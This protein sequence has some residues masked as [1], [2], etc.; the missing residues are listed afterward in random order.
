M[1]RLHVA[2]MQHETC[3]LQHFGHSGID[4]GTHYSTF[5][6]LEVR[7]GHDNWWILNHK[8]NQLGKIDV[9]LFWNAATDETFIVEQGDIALDQPT[10]LYQ[11][12][13]GRYLALQGESIALPQEFDMLYA[14]K[15][16]ILLQWETT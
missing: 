6:N 13:L 16:K 12:A 9:A 1:H 15:S 14:A 10:I 3:L 2:T 4:R 8:S 5:G 11:R 7:P